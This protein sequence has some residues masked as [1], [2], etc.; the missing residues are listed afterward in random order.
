ME[1]QDPKQGGLYES[2]GSFRQGEDISKSDVDI[3]IE[4]EEFD[5]YKVVELDELSVFEKKINKEIQLH[6]FNRKS[7]DLNVFNNL[8]NGIVLSGFLEVKK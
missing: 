7:I 5:K 1:H 8:A 3:A 2:I 4:S 6:L